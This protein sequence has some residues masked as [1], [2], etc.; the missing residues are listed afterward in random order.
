MTEEEG[1]EGN[2]NLD[3]FKEEINNRLDNYFSENKN[4]LLSYGDLEDFLKAIELYEY[5]NTEDEKD[6]IWQKLKKYS[7]DDKV[8]SEG[9]KKGMHDFINFLQNGDEEN[10]NDGYLLSNIDNNDIKKERKESK[11]EN[12]FTVIGVTDFL[13]NYI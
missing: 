11:D 9:I 2:I 7:K 5:W 10:E 4:V 6:A 1:E 8:D 12:G 13:L 3:E